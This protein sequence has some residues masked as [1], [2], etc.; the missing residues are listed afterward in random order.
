MRSWRSSR[1][2]RRFGS[3]WVR[4]GGTVAGCVQFKQQPESALTH[5]IAI[6][7]VGVTC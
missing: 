1:H 7:S 5:Y 3:N 4:V 2:E 6:G